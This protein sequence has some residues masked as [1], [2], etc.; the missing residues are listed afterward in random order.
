MKGNFARIK[1]I[2]SENESIQLQRICIEKGFNFSLF[3]RFLKK[4]SVNDFIFASYL[5]LHP[6]TTQNCRKTLSY[7]IF[8]LE[9]F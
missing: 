6:N 8:H 1:N 5:L 4:R 3:L 7:M 2:L 9:L